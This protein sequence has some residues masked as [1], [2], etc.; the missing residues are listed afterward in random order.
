MLRGN[1]TIPVLSGATAVGNPGQ[2]RQSERQKK[3]QSDL[4]TYGWY[5]TEPS[6]PP[7]SGNPLRLSG[8]QEASL[9]GKFRFLLYCYIDYAQPLNVSMLRLSSAHT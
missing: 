6:S 3:Y 8:L 4:P 9:W 7:M 1:S 2:D 5:V